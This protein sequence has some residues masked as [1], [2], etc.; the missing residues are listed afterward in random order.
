MVQL[1][2]NLQFTRT[3]C[4]VRSSLAGGIVSPGA[5]VDVLVWVEVLPVLGE[6]PLDRVIGTPAPA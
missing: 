3:R 6:V 2:S 1:A 5:G 4:S